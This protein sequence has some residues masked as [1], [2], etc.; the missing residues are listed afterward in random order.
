VNAP[1]RGHHLRV[2]DR[3]RRSDVI[4]PAHRRIANG[5]LEDAEQIG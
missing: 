1:Q 3:L 2:G 5:S 4:Q